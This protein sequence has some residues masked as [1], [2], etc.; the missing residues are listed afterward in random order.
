MTIRLGWTCLLPPRSKELSEGDSNC[1]RLRICTCICLVW[2]QLRKYFC[3]HSL[4]A[5]RHYT[6]WMNHGSCAYHLELLPDGAAYEHPALCYKHLMSTPP[7]VVC[8]LVWHM[9]IPP[10][11]LSDSEV[12]LHESLVNASWTSWPN[13]LTTS[14]YLAERHYAVLWCR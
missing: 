3:M 9:S 14:S 12:Y 13:V 8:L 11:R 2:D 1:D 5:E 6:V 4:C 7:W 10:C